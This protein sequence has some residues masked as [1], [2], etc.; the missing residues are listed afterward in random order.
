MKNTL[1]LL[2]TM[3]SL[4][5]LSQNTNIILQVNEKT[6]DYGEVSN[7]YIDILNSDI[8]EKYY[9]KYYPGDLIFDE[10]IWNK[11]NSD[12]IGK[13]RLNFDYYT[14]KKGKQQI[15]NFHV[16]L[17]KKLLNQHYLIIDVYDFRDKKYKRWY[18]YITKEDYLVELIYPQSGRYIR[19][20][21]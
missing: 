19:M 1:L 21:N 12:S 14:Y 18:Q 8:P 20:E 6:L 2:T 9:L 3:F 13:V 16:E 11:I 7:L 10:K 15:A 17:N 5:L 4:S